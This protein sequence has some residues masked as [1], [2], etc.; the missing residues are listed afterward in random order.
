MSMTPPR[1]LIK[2]AVVFAILGLLVIVFI[3]LLPVTTKWLVND[4]F[5]EQ[6]ISS[7]IDDITFSLFDGQVKVTSLKA[8]APGK[9]EIKL[10]EFAVRIKLRDLWDKKIT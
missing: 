10:G 2:L 4:W 7:Q 9:R 5:E 3:T 6:G 1:Y 8:T